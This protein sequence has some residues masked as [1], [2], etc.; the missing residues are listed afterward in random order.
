[1]KFISLRMWHGQYC[2]YAVSMDLWK[3]MLSGHSLKG[4]LTVWNSF[5]PPY[6]SLDNTFNLDHIPFR[7]LSSITK[8]NRH[9]SLD[10]VA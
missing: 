8:Y 10:Y 2:V 4:D 6:F 5:D 1:M 9:F 7:P 3:I